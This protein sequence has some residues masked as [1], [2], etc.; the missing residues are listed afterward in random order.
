[1][2]LCDTQEEGILN[3][4]RMNFVKILPGLFRMT[5]SQTTRH[6]PS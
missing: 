2:S 5:A 6:R 1:M 3:M 4:A